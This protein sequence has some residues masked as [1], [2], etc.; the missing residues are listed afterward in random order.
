[1]AL[2]R[3]T[4]CAILCCVLLGL[5]AWAQDP[6]ETPRQDGVILL[7][8]FGLLYAVGEADSNAL[9]FAG[10][11][12]DLGFLIG[13]DL[14]LVGDAD[15]TV[16]GGYALDGFG[17]QFSLGAVR[18][19]LE[20][21]QGGALPFFGW[22]IA[23]DLEIAP[24]WRT[25]SDDGYTYHGYLVLD[26]LGGVHPVGKVNL[27]QYPFGPGGAMVY[28]PYPESLL[29]TETPTAVIRGGPINE[30]SIARPIFTYFNWD[31]AR[32][33]EISTQFVTIT[34]TLLLSPEFKS[35]SVAEGITPKF[36]AATST[37]GGM[38]VGLCNGYYILDGLGAVHSC[39][40]PLEFDMN[41][42]GLITPSDLANPDFGRPANYRPLVAPWYDDDLPYFG[43]D[44]ARDVELTPTR[45]GFYLLDGFGKVHMV[46]D[47]HYAFPENPNETP[48]FGFDIA[49][50]LATVPNESGSGI[51]GY[52]VL[53]GFG[54]VYKSGLAKDYDISF[55]GDNGKPVL[56]F[57]DS[58]RDVEIT[59][60]F[61]GATAP[62]SNPG[63]MISVAPAGSDLTNINLIYSPDVSHQV[64]PFF[65]VSTA[66][67]PFF[68][69]VT[70]L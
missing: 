31:I 40:L 12:L 68:D 3:L 16:V 56:S 65:E 36:A 54:Q 6:S 4:F 28:T 46:G 21:S 62:A 63:Y 34:T 29:T 58:L 18:T 37:P 35:A 13:R 66:P 25:A 52:L 23:Q 1:M 2:K 41:D 45:N 7:D 26:G 39:R 33:L 19:P 42:D 22:D 14:E 50:A 9:D 47:A 24:D 8:G 20:L 17:S 5:S 57:V 67:Y 11:S 48:Y 32:D 27:P 64:V 55:T 43:F 51:L 30:T 49:R 44:I 10:T 15:G 53:D 59:P 70:G 69:F 38:L 61:F 60:V